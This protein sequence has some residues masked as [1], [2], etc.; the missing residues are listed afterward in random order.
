MYNSKAKQG[1][2]TTAG[3]LF[4]GKHKYRPRTQSR[5][6]QA[7]QMRHPPRDHRAIFVLTEASFKI[8]IEISSDV[9]HHPHFLFNKAELQIELNDFNPKVFLWHCTFFIGTRRMLSHWSHCAT[10]MMKGRKLASE[11][12]V[13]TNCQLQCLP[14]HTERFY[15]FWCVWLLL[16]S[17]RFCKNWGYTLNMNRVY[18]G[19]L[20]RLKYYLQTQVLDAVGQ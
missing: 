3:E 18:Y 15:S 17:I 11:L 5:I 1:S 9:F 16:V 2:P 7:S 12:R 13:V 10:G 8:N 6:C 14:R 20:P 4:P 19:C